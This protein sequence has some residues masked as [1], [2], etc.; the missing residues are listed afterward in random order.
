MMM[1]LKRMI[2]MM[3]MYMMLNLCFGLKVEA[4]ISLNQVSQYTNIYDTSKSNE[5]EFNMNSWV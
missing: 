5:E 4:A 2:S 3:C 1:D